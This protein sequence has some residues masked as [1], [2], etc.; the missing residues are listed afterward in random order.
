M[1][2]FWAII[3]VIFVVLSAQAGLFPTVIV[4]DT[5]DFAWKGAKFRIVSSYDPFNPPFSPPSS[6]QGNYDDV[7]PDV[8][9][10]G[11]V[12]FT[13]KYSSS[14]GNLFQGNGTQ[15]TDGH[16]LDFV[17]A[18]APQPRYIAF[19]TNRFGGFHIAVL[20]RKTSQIYQVTNGPR[21]AEPDFCIDQ[22]TGNQYLIFT[23]AK[24]GD[25]DI[26]RLPWDGA[27]PASPWGEGAFVNLTNDPT[28]DQ[29]EA[30]CDNSGI[31][32]PV[33]FFAEGWTKN[34]P[35]SPN[36]SISDFDIVSQSFLTPGA[37]RAVRYTDGNSTRP[38][39]SW[40]GKYICF[41]KDPPTWADRGA[42]EIWVMHRSGSPAWNA[43]ENADTVDKQCSW[44][45]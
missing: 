7:V 38:A 12:V 35:R 32:S 23:L 34:D 43:T 41:T 11:A 2:R 33:I 3:A 9:R 36:P 6:S 25:R 13:R 22:A 28:R 19:G 44:R 17:P 20:D 39:V 26:A 5:I 18:W 21:E 14:H 31:G 15:L 10:G 29:M 8:A 27:P 24:D 1:R 16:Y 30:S 37:N 40:D 42:R 45:N 4:A